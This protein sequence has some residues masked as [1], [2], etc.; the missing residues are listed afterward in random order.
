MSDDALHTVAA[1]AVIFA[2]DERGTPHVLVIERSDDSDAYPGCSALPG[3]LVEAG[4]PTEAAARRELAE[5][6]GVTAPEALHLVGVFDA[7]GRDPRGHVIGV[8]YTGTL[9]AMVEPV[10]ADDAQDA[11]WVAVETLLRVPGALAFDHDQIL[12]AA[13]RT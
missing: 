6:T 13:L 12:A 5:E 9:P 7:P 10:A 3:G 1:D 2:P 8:A 11:K 4:E